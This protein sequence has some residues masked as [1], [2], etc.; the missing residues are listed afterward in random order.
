MKSNETNQIFQYNKKCNFF[1]LNEQIP[2]SR[3]NKMDENPKIVLHVVILELVYPDPQ[4]PIKK[5][6]AP[7]I[8]NFHFS[9]FTFF[10][11]TFCT[12]TFTFIT[13]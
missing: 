9:H 10:V 3:K 4:L 12:F 6:E 7:K 11:F 1:T 2:A 8:D 5:N 13:S